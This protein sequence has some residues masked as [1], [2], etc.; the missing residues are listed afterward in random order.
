MEV[1]T[2]LKPGQSGAALGAKAGQSGLADGQTSLGSK[3]SSAFA[4]PKQMA[5]AGARAGAR[6]ASIPEV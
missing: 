4:A 5:R 1:E 6:V 2:A 3:H